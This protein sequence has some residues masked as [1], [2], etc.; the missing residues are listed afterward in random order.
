MKV[1]KSRWNNAIV[2]LEENKILIGGIYKIQMV[3]LKEKK[4]EKEII[5]HNRIIFSLNLLF[6]NYFLS[7]DNFGNIELREIDTLKDIKTKYLEYQAIVYSIKNL[8][9]NFFL[10][11]TKNKTMYLMKY[12]LN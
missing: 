6:D 11:S 2:K 8:Y 3:N 9:D 12:N 7:G 5:T 1:C 10:V 4:I